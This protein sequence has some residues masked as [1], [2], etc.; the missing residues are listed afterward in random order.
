MLL[1]SLTSWLT[2][3]SIVFNVVVKRKQKQ[4]QQK[5]LNQKHKHI[6]EKNFV[7]L[8]PRSGKSLVVTVFS[9]F[10]EILFFIFVFVFYSFFTKNVNVSCI[11]KMITYV[12]GWFYTKQG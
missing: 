11:I 1:Y 8:A 3:K 6:H 4:N 2:P 5:N 10:F 7:K 9:Y 12:Q